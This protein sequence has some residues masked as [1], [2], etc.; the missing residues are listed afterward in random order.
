M[1]LFSLLACA[2]LTIAL[3]SFKY[4]DKK[5]V[6]HQTTYEIDKD[7]SVLGWKGGTNPTYFHTGVVKFS[8]GSAV[9]EHGA[10]VSGDFAVDLTTIKVNDAG[11]SAEK[12]EGLAKHLKAED[13]FNVAK[14]ASAKVAIGAYKDGKL[15]T[16][17]NLLGV[18]IK[19]DL[20]V[21]I[22]ATD[23]GATI[24]GKFDVDFTAANIPG[25]QKE[26]GDKESISPVFS[27]DLNLVLKA[28]N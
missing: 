20:P 12:Q 18:D 7:L 3:V 22:T 1:K 23:K 21:T 8:S 9:M 13:F 26:E 16:T 25:T 27:F 14:F 6:K 17:I 15:S 11:L 5:E 28:K 24:T 4:A 19:Q 2:S 10:V